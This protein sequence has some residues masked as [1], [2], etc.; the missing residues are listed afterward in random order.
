MNVLFLLRRPGTIRNYAST[1]ALL[2][3][4]DHRV[5]ILYS[6]LVA[7]STGPDD[8]G[9]TKELA[10]RFPNVT[11]AEATGRAAAD[12]W[13]GT[14]RVIRV[15]GDF[16]RY[17]HPRFAD[18][19][20]LRARAAHRAKL[21][22]RPR[23]VG[24][25]GAAFGF[26]LV[27][28]LSRVRSAAVADALGGLFRRLEDAIPPSPAV[29][30][31]LRRSRPDVILVSP[32]VDTGS[33]QA[34]YVKAAQALRIPSAAAIASWDNLST[35]GAMR[36]RPDRVFVWNDVQRREAA[37]MHGIPA[38][39]VV[40]TGAPRFDPWFDRAPSRPREAFV[41]E[42]GLSEGPY[43]LYLCSSPFIAPNEVPF[44]ER[45]AKAIRASDDSAVREL[46]LLVRPYPQNTEIWKDLTVD[47]VA[48]WPRT[49][50]YVDDEASAADFYDAIAH[51]AVVV[52]INTSALIEAAIAGKNV[53]TVLDGDFAGTQRGT[54]HYHYLLY[55]NG[56]FLREASSLREH[57]S[58][59]SAVL[60]A[61][62]ASEEQTRRFVASFV[63]PLG[64]GVSA[65]EALADSIE[66][67]ATIPA[68]EV[69]PLPRGGLF[70]LVLS[71]GAALRRRRRARSA[72][73]AQGP[74][75]EQRAAALERQL[76]AEKPPQT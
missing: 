46:G 47:G 29:E 59:L 19:P 21:A 53:L 18:A 40:L 24:T 20:L 71:A 70:R 22:V 44:V 39:R 38:E 31:A 37:E 67:L 41:H 5:E 34:D 1:I 6:R 33:D 28:L 76:Q 52:G 14:A 50:A 66:Q 26:R 11:Y 4:R 61:A 36:V 2:A 74:K 17:L 62:A 10:D 48:V 23:R 25:G 56:G 42:V 32:L 27:D 12:G 54:I 35:K 57:V 8:L 72:G 68:K 55:E 7:K 58:Q 51:S 63:R 65:T 73:Q 3:E 69:E 16:V 43:T 15:W 49:A 60:G 13:V 9:P 64:P 45:W 75:A 30:T